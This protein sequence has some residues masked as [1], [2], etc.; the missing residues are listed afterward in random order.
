MGVNM[1]RHH[2]ADAPWAN[3]NIFGNK[4]NTLHLDP[5]ALDRFDYFIAQLQK[6]GIYQ[7]FDLL[8]HRAPL[9]TDGVRAPKT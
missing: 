7:Y 4:E 1:T 3:P 6:R 8:V 5:E 9:A 2:H